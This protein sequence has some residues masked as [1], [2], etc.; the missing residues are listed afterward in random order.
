MTLISAKIRTL[1]DAVIE[2]SPI[3]NQKNRDPNVA[4]LRTAQNLME[5]LRTA[6]EEELVSLEETL[7]HVIARRRHQDL[8]FGKEV[9]YNC[10]CLN[11]FFN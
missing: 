4:G 6:D 9:F 10:F 3:K 11:I 8:V 5:L 2:F 7:Y 1:F